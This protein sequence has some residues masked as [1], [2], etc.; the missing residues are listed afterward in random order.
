M[1]ASC[2]GVIFDRHQLAQAVH[3]GALWSL[4]GSSNHLC[5]SGF[6][7]LTSPHPA[8]VFVVKPALVAAP[9]GLRIVGSRILA[10]SSTTASAQDILAL[11]D[12]ETSCSISCG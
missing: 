3:K 1:A 10:R 4:G 9:L 11:T 12:G 6:P 7:F 2:C 8:H 5:R